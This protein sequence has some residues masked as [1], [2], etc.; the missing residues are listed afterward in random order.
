[1]KTISIISRFLQAGSLPHM[2]CGLILV[3]SAIFVPAVYA[4]SPD[5]V[6]LQ[7]LTQSP[8]TLK[9]VGKVSVLGEEL[10]SVSNLPDPEVEGEYLVAPAGETNRWGAGISWGLEW[11][12]VYSA[13]RA[14]ADG[15]L[16]VA[17]AE[18]MV[19]RNETLTEIQNYLLDYI[20][21]SSQL[22]MLKEIQAANDSVSLLAERSFKGGEVTRLDLGKLRIERASIAA[23]IA[24]VETS[25]MEAKA[26]LSELNGSDCSSLLEG[27]DTQLPH[28]VVPTRQDIDNALAASPEVVAAYRRLEQARLEGKVAAREGLPNLT[29]GYN[30]AF[31]DGIHFNGASLGISIPMFSNRGKKHAAK[32]KETVAEAELEMARNQVGLTLEDGVARLNRMNARIEDLS[33]AIDSTDDMALLSKAYSGGLITLIDY[34]NERNYFLEARFS[35]LDL[36]YNAAKLRLTLHSLLPRNL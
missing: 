29:I 27:L 20:F 6:A 32:V 23:R 9:G 10:R 12:G 1:M 21:A 26:S 11:P 5:E 28:A 15:Q 7:I 4:V 19:S 24:E 34:I 13:R 22:K 35:L 14:A 2:R 33:K 18:M 16:N 25:L 8:E 3:A 31:E 30:H 17:M 36:R